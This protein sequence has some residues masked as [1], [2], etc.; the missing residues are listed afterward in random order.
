[1]ASPKSWCQFSGWSGDC[2][3]TSPRCRL[4]LDSDKTVTASFKRIPNRLSFEERAALYQAANAR[5]NA[6]MAVA[7]STLFQCL[8]D[9]PE[10]KQPCFDGYQAAFDVSIA[11]YEADRAK[12]AAMP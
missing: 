10:N 11:I 2:S 12:I 8:D 7:A 4:K 9:Q 3:G 1:M 5:H 6:R